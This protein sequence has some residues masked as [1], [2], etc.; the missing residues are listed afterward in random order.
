MSRAVALDQAN[1][2]RTSFL[3]RRATFLEH[4][5]EAT[6]GVNF[7]PCFRSVAAGGSEPKEPEA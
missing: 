4:L 6:V 5:A 3:E 1:S 2:R 7:A